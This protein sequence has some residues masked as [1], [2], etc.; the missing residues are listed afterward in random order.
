MSIQGKLTR[1]TMRGATCP[2]HSPAFHEPP[3]QFKGAKWTVYEYETDAEVAAELVP[4][5]LELAEV[6]VASLN[7]IEYPWS[8]LG[9]YNDAF[10]SIQ[11]IYEGKEYNYIPYLISDSDVKLKI[12]SVTE[13]PKK[14]G[15]VRFTYQNNHLLAAVE[16]PAGVVIA[17]ARIERK[18][19]TE[20]VSF[21]LFPF[22]TLQNNDDSMSAKEPSLAL[23]EPL[24]ELNPVASW[25]A[26]AD[27]D[28]TGASVIDPWHKLPIIRPLECRQFELDGS[29]S[30]GKLVACF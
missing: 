27:C 7:F 22:L 5:I 25:D 1:T 6:P 23:I 29:V 20:T 24:L 28:L 15:V 11:C 30:S 3:F 12:S 26:V 4:H 19:K 18:K 10:L 8:N 9:I 14:T 16:R 13:R 21:P 17:K 2:T